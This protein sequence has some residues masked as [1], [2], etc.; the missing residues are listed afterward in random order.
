M[1]TAP[2]MPEV[3]YERG[4]RMRLEEYLRT[5]FHPDREYVDGVAEERIAGET[6]ELTVPGTEVRFTAAEVFSVLG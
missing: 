6:E 4:T 5:M 2:A 3:Q 1:S